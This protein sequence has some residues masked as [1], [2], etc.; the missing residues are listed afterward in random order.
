MGHECVVCHKRRPIRKRGTNE[1]DDAVLLWLSGQEPRVRQAILLQNPRHFAAHSKH[2]FEPM[3][4]LATQPQ[5]NSAVVFAAGD[6][7]NQRQGEG[8]P[9][10]IGEFK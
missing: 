4:H 5:N 3:P 7:Q 6:R 8:N 9:Q 1:G 10:F 2:L